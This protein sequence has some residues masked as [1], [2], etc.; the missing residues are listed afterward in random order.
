MRIGIDV[1]YLSHGLVGG[2]HT[3]LRG[4]VPAL[5]QAAA[6]HE[7]FLYADTKRRFELE[8]LPRHVTVRY[9]P[10]RSALDSL[11]LDFTLSRHMRQDRIDVSHFPA[12]YG[13][14]PRSARTVVT[15]HDGLNLMPL[16]PGL[17]EQRGVRDL[18]TDALTCY[19]YFM[20][21][22]AIRRAARIL[23]VS[24]FS[25]R[26][27]VQ[28]ARL[29]PARVVV[30]PHAPNADVRRNEDHQ[31]LAALRSQLGLPES[32]I[33]ADALKNP[34]AVVGAWRLL[35]PEVRSQRQIAFFAR[36][37]Q[38]RPIV[39]QAV[40]AGEA[41]LLS[42]PERGELMSLYSA[43]QAFVFPSWIEG[44]GIPIIEAM[45]CG[46]PVIASN[47]GAIPEVA[48]DA[49]LLVDPED[50][51][52][53]AAQLRRV[54]TDPAEAARLRD[55]GRKRSSEFSWTESARRT[56][57]CYEGAA[58]E[59]RPTIGQSGPRRFT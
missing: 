21:T 43:C 36:G 52:G 53:L 27:L 45:V 41:V 16:L 34:E 20:S 42:R 56:L 59:S 47:R 5:A 3:Y 4:L 19:L 22:A 13:F 54:L 33:L 7:L 11:L 50:H 38:T 8:S 51:P 37:K 30:A 44:F 29:N 24:E 35:P 12:N 28:L 10:W 26:E 55:L 40:A 14:G 49:A 39:S 25:K 32:F 57:A 58:A 31:A 23:T 46:A 6:E 18:R 2:I 17:L 48:G 15:L 9:L 1:R